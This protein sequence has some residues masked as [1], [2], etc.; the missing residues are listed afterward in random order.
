MKKCNSDGPRSERRQELGAEPPPEGAKTCKDQKLPWPDALRERKPPSSRLQP[1]KPA[2]RGRG[3]SPLP[4]SENCKQPAPVG[5][6]G[7]LANAGSGPPCGSKPKCRTLDV[8]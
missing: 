3:T 6:A 5:R 7:T 1:G 2:P 8:A 4:Q